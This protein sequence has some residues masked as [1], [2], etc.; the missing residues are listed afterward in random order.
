MPQQRL[1]ATEVTTGG[2]WGI[3]FAIARRLKTDGHPIAV[4]SSGEADA[5]TRA[6][7]LDS[8]ERQLGLNKV[9]V[10]NAASRPLSGWMCATP[11][12]RIL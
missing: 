9:L 11:R 3:G 6:A 5:P 10:S 12:R 4:T 2:R 7:V 1:D 8:I